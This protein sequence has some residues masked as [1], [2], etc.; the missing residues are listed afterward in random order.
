MHYF[1]ADERLRRMPGTL[2]YLVTLDTA[3]SVLTQA[4]DAYLTFLKSLQPE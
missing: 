4:R 1:H 2:Y 3:D